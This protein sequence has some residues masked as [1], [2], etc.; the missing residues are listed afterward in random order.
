MRNQRRKSCGG[1]TYFYI[2]ERWCTDVTVLKKMCCSDLEALFINCKPF[3]LPQ[4]F[5][6]FILVSVYINT[7]SSNPLSPTTALKLSEDDVCQVFRKNERRKAPGPG[8]VST[9]C[10]K[11]WADQ[12]DPYSHRSSTDHWSC[13][14]S[15][16]ASNAP[17][18][19]PSQRNPKLVDLM[20]TDLWL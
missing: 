11:S 13:A 8:G 4:E 2:N 18:S 5:C 3:Y 17:P 7:S 14:K 16:H 12:L 20:T 10:L 6:S 19:S 9:V 15:P 1:G